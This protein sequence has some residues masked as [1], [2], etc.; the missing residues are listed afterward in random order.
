M[1]E[2]PDTPEGIIASMDVSDWTLSQEREFLENLYVGRFNFFLVVFS[3]FVTAGFANNFSTY[4][5]AV[6]VAG[7]VVLFL[8]WLTLFR[9]YRKLDRVLRIIFRD[10]PDHITSKIE[11]I[12]RL[13]GFDPRYRVSRLMG[14]YIP[15][16]C[17]IV[18][19]AAAVAIATG[20]LR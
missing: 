3:L 17:I 20:H 6:F 1:L 7:S 19:L 9:A 4:K 5:A 14:V 18:L 12:M 11:R 2:S 8:L 15:W 10:K 16:L 13:E